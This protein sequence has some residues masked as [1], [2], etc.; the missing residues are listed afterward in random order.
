MEVST[1]MCS[2]CM[3]MT[4]VCMKQQHGAITDRKYETF[5]TSLMKLIKTKKV[6]INFKKK[7]KEE[8]NYYPV[9]SYISPLTTVF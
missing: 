5:L 1:G 4:K 3:F 9:S 6:T 2:M 7:K 8:P